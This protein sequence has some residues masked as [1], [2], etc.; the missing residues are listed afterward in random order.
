MGSERLLLLK[1]TVRLQRL[2]T[3]HSACRTLLAANLSLLSRDGLL[4]TLLR[5][6]GRNG[7][8]LTLGL[9]LGLSLLLGLEISLLLLLL[10]EGLLPV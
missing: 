6:L 3:S 2:L 9:N 10:L 1:R 4:L 5:L 7:L 8:L